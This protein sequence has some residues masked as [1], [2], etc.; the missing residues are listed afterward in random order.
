MGIPVVSDAA[1]MA[2]AL[3]DTAALIEEAGAAGLA[4]TCY[5]DRA[6]ILVT[7]CAGSARHRAALVAALG[8]LAGAARCRQCDI[9]GERPSAWL[10]AAGRAGSTVIEVTT[11]LAVRSV[12][13]GTVA[14]GPDGQQA[15]IASGQQPPPGW[16]W[17]TELDDQ[18]GDEPARRRE[19]A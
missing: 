3:L 4:V 2:A 8:E 5:S 10:E 9:A 17:V 16:R 18:P 6:R 1:A 15:V 12:P 7:S 14:A 11:P 13:G 19:A